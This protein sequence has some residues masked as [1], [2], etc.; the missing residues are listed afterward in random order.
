MKHF[1]IEYDTE[2]GTANFAGEYESFS[3]FIAEADKAGREAGV[4]GVD[5]SVLDCD[6]EIHGG[7]FE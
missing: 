2:Y 5:E 4:L 3:A 7:V 6:N 1:E